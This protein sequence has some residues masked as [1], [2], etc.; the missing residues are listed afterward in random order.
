MKKSILAL[1]AAV[2]VGGLGFA[3]A[4]HAV[5]FFG[6]DPAPVATAPAAATALELNPGAVGHMLYTPY[7]NTQASTATLI[8][9]T[10]T[11]T[12]N[13][14]AVKVRF[15][16]A[17]NSDDLLDFTLLLS[18]GDVWTANVQTLKGFSA[19]TTTDTSCTLPKIPAAG[20]PLVSDRLPSYVADVANQTREGYIEILNMAD[21][22]V[23]AN[24]S[25][26]YASIKHKA[27]TPL[28]C[29]AAAVQSVLLD[30]STNPTVAGLNGATG[31]LMGSWALVNQGELAVYSGNMPAVRAVSAPGVNGTAYINIAPQL[32]VSYAA[33]SAFTADPL[34]KPVTAGGAAKTPLYYDVPDMSTPL[35]AGVTP[36]QQIVQMD[37]LHNAVMNEYVADKDGAVPM[38]TDWVVSQPTRRYYAAVDYGSSATTAQK[39]ENSIITPNPYTGATLQTVGGMPMLC[40]AGSV[41]TSDR[42]E[43]SIA[44]GAQFSPGTAASFCGEVFT[45]SFG[46]N[47]SVLNALV[48]NQAVPAAGKAGWGYVSLVGSQRLPIVGFSATS[49]ANRAAGGNYGV[50]LPHRW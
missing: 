46:G 14:K 21:I 44:T 47:G 26:L 6:A 25:S 43:G 23:N 8:N 50:T 45:L 5:V 40:V 20:A 19:L 11:D 31:G 33:G 27:G 29:D 39:I 37:I 48:T 1:G 2:A 15:R 42:E 41:G 36:E 17:A 9:I 3:G 18:P 28:N 38:T 12:I 34:Y 10:N 35:F 22:P 7:F 30:G 4:A 32:A 13:G 16:G 49:A 24:T